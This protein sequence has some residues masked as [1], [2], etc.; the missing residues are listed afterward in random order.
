M[1]ARQV[2]YHLSHSTSPEIVL[3]GGEGS[4]MRENDGGGELNHGTL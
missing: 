3:S 1:H 2:L 4:V